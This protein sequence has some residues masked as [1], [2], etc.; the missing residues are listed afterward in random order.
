MRK[1][2]V[3]LVL[4]A[5]AWTQLQ[6]QQKF[7]D[8]PKLVVG[9]VVD[10]MRW[11]YL[12]VSLTIFLRLLLLDIRVPIQVLLLLSMALVAIPFILMDVRLIVVVMKMLVP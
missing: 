5:C 6:A 4:M 1:A 9:I 10:Q 12:S 2:I 7:N 11:D 3:L 8:R